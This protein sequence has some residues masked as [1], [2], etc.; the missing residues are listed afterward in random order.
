MYGHTSRPTVTLEINERKW[1]GTAATVAL[2]PPMKIVHVVYSLDMG[3]AEVLV[4]QLCRMQRAHGH[5]V[6]ICAY[7]RLGS[8]GEMLREE[9]IEIYVPGEAHPAATMLRYFKHFRA[10]R[11]DVVHCHNVAPTIQAALAARL[12]GAKRVLST[13]H[14]LVAPPYNVAEEVKYGVMATCCDWIAG[15]CEATC[16]NLRGA[17]M[18]HRNKIVRV[19]NGASAIETVPFD[20]LGKRGF[21]L[22]FVGR[23]A[24]VKNLQT[25]IRAVSIAVKQLPEL[26]FWIVGDGPVRGE[27]EALAAELGVAGH[28]RFWG[29]RLDTAKFFSAADA[30]VMSS[31]SEGL[32]MSLLQAMSIGVPAIVTDVGGMAEV[33]R[34]SGAGLLAPVGDS[35]AMANAIVS[36]AGDPEMRAEF[37]DR[38]KNTCAAEFTLER[39]D[40]AYMDLYSRSR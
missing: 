27:L 12:A 35:P 4:A 19:Y 33:V 29:Q 23:L 3:G 40:A 20:D 2:K 18:A 31:V 22:V 15:I 10:L 8:V 24:E 1:D 38:A 25:L 6:S 17:P 26:E 36:L 34:L 14:S 16:N 21:T 32:P 39:M 7:S 37:S 9:G 28:V 13:R 11:P 30:L 5:Q